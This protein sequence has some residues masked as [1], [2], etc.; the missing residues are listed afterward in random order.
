LIH[1]RL[2]YRDIPVIV[3]GPLPFGCVLIAL[4]HIA[5]GLFGCPSGAWVFFTPIVIVL[6][7][8]AQHRY[9]RLWRAHRTQVFAAT[10][11]A[12]VLTAALILRIA[13][14]R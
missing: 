10:L 13:R 9:V 3:F 6:V 14:R 8:S 11:L 12:Y 7:V 5:C 1:P 2:T 4:S